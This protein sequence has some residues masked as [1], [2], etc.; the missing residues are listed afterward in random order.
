MAAELREKSNVS[1]D[2]ERKR[3]DDSNCI[4]LVWS[5]AC[6]HQGNQLGSRC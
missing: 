5:D 4:L 2:S 1:V 3:N 6:Q